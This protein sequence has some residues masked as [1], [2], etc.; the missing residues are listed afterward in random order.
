MDL[1][2]AKLTKLGKGLKKNNVAVDVVAMGESETNE[3]KLR[4]FVESVDK[5]GNSHLIVIPAGVMPSEVLMTS[6]IVTGGEEGGGGA[7]AAGAGGAASGGAAASAFAEYGGVDP[8][9]DPELAMALR[10][11]MEE[12]RTRLAAQADAEPQQQ[13]SSDVA[14]GAATVVEE[15]KTSNE[16][17]PT[18]VP[19]TEDEEEMLRRALL[20]SMGESEQPF[21]DKSEAQAPPPSVVGNPACLTRPSRRS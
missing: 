11:S 17:P 6:P 12:E 21:P 3:S 1:D 19:A 18:N 10:A 15:Q 9:L 13:P 20:M 8:T 7:G 4:A 16:Q 14:D 5:N 2:E